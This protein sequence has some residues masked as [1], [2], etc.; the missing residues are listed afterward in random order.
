VTVG[1]WSK[2]GWRVSEVIDEAVLDASDLGRRGVGGE[3]PVVEQM[4]NRHT[5]QYNECVARSR[6]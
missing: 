1:A 3:T 2:K 6:R 5:T 4:C